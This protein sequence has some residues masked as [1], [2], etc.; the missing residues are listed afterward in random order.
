MTA[1]H[2]PT[3]VA[4]PGQPLFSSGSTFQGFGQ[5]FPGCFSPQSF[6]T[7]STELSLPDSPVERDAPDHLTKNL[8]GVTGV[9]GVGGEMSCSSQL[10][11]KDDMRSKFSSLPSSTAVQGGGELV[12][13]QASTSLFPSPGGKMKELSEKTSASKSFHPLTASQKSYSHRHGDRHLQERMSHPEF[14]VSKRDVHVANRAK[15]Y[16]D[17]FHSNTS[18]GK[19]APAL[20]SASRER[21]NS[22]S[23]ILCDTLVFNPA[24]QHHHSSKT[25]A[26]LHPLLHSVRSS[27]TALAHQFG[28]SPDHLKSLS[29]LSLSPSPP[30]SSYSTPDP[31]LCPS[32]SFEEVDYDI[33]EGPL[34]VKVWSEE[35]GRETYAMLLYKAQLRDALVQLRSQ[36]HQGD[37]VL[38]KVSEER[39]GERE[40]DRGRGG[41]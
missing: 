39:D 27:L 11:K 20:L 24:P 12:M 28:L 5:N 35:G 4:M 23:S 16:N 38:L 2:L 9:L 31:S 25:P 18:S 21:I 22:L 7:L 37:I 17:V 15:S 33:V 34:E 8:R 30:T 29:N 19:R 1:Q 36:M 10:L 14:H 6:S 3:S 41:G 26:N 40:R 32:L 13:T